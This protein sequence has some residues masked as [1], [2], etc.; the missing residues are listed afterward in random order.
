MIGQNISHYRVIEKL[1]GGGMGVVYKAEDT[2]LKR[3]VALKFLPEDVTRDVAAL[4]RF[5]REAQAASALNHP[6]ICTIYD[7]GEEGEQAFIV[8]E[9][10]EGETLKHLIDSRP[11]EIE[12][13]LGIAIDVADALDA[14]H[15]KGIVHRDIKPAN[16]F[17]TRRGAAKILDFGLAK[18][19]QESSRALDPTEATKTEGDSAQHL[20]SPGSA[21]GT[22]AYMSPEQVRGKA[23][24]QRT[25]L[26]SFGIVLY[27][28]ATGALPFRGETSGVIFDEILNRAPAAPVRLNPKLPSKLEDVI[29]RALEKDRDLRY[30]HAVDLKSEL[31][32]LKRD[33]DSGRSGASSSSSSSSV[34]SAEE[35]S[36]PSPEPLPAAHKTSGSA[37]VVTAG[38]SG[39]IPAATETAPGSARLKWMIPAAVVLILAVIAGGFYFR[40]RPTVQLTDKDQLILADFTNQTGDSV[41][42]STL[43]EALAIQLEQSPLLQLVSDAE[44]HSNLQYLGQA[45][46]QR[47]TP[48]LAQQLGQRLGVK[49]YLAGSIAN[50]GTSYVI[51]INAVNVATGEVFAREQVTAPDKTAVLQA[52]SQAATAMR[53]GLGESM[54]SIQKL[55][56]P[57]TNVTTASLQAFHAFSL[58]ED[59]HRMGRDFPQ[60][61]SFYQ[62]AIQLDPNFAMAYARLGVTY[63]TQG[64]LAKALE[65][66]KKAYELREHVTERE[67]MY[68]ESSYENF[69]YDLPRALESY[70]LFAATYPR[71]AAAWNNMAIVYV[72]TGDYEQAA[73]GFEKTWEIANWDTVAA[74]NAGATL[75]M[76][77]R[78]SD[79]DGYMKVALAHGAENS[80]SYRTYVVMD[81]FLSGHAD[82]EDSVQWAASRPNGFLVDATAASVNFYLGRM[83]QADQ[84]WDQAANRAEQQHLSDSAGGLYAIKAVHDAL[85][86]NCNAAR[87]A[88]H[89]GLAL[90]QSIS[91]VP[92]TTLALALC[93]ES[94]PALKAIEPAAA[95][96]P[97]N[98]LYNDIYLPE[99]KAAVALVEHHPDQVAGL[100]SP[101]SPYLLVS[102]A[103]HLAGRASLE[104]KKAQ[105]ALTDFEPGLRYRAL[106]LGEGPGAGQSPDYPLCLLGT[107]RAQAQFDKAAATKSYQQ[108]LDIWKNADADFIP[109]QEARR[110]FAALNAAAKN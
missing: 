104:M 13:L 65:Y 72:E 103:P 71:D 96:A 4:S 107:A 82:W 88:A 2:R 64:A 62:Q 31:L 26:F 101:V 34:R 79:G 59:E 94:G 47:I 50:L 15:S 95:D 21:L 12:K 22:V 110:E 74:L 46:D 92:D 33:L 7:I 53:A 83:H 91:T 99:V 68:I 3:F 52:V 44:L 20:T 40:K 18:V 55:T 76:L 98:T 27:E 56:T 89:K 100:L 61:Q 37:R 29:N 24:D 87:D 19:T 8:M 41:F 85:V 10:L 1:G 75:M 6:N 70:K 93:G 60:A 54:A 39:K 102:K 106:V 73:A 48:E 38:S 58:G 78:L 5:R 97:N 105:Q 23:L 49:A 36:T 51:Q 25:D 32:R 28:M 108:L 84:L 69:Q 109:A 43:K 66:M 67:R 30:Q 17:V 90:D 86:S 35:S 77:G 9:Y 42:D 14:A 16:I 11:L 80:V 81:D 45:K 63:S 57:Y